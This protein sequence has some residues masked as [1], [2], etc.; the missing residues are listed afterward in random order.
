M[1]AIS[2]WPE[3][4]WAMV[5]LGLNIESRPYAPPRAISIGQMVAIYASSKI[6]G[7]YQPGFSR[8]GTARALLDVADVA[9]R[10]VSG[11]KRVIVYDDYDKVCGI[12]FIKKDEVK[13]LRSAKLDTGRIVAVAK[14]IRVSDPVMSRSDMDTRKM[15]PWGEVGRHW[16]VFGDIVPIHTGVPYG[17]LEVRARAWKLSNNAEKTVMEAMASKCK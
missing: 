6:A 11:M 14:L 17:D 4:A 12:D 3:R 8:M 15:E 7:R 13:K 10:S 16:W 5:H 9:L 1:H 2:M